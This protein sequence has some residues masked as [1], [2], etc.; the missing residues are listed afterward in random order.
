MSTKQKWQIVA[1]TIIT[2]VIVAGIVL[3]VIYTNRGAKGPQQATNVTVQ[4]PAGTQPNQPAGVPPTTPP[5]VSSN[6][7]GAPSV[8]TTPRQGAGTTVTP[9]PASQPKTPQPSKTTEA[10]QPTQGARQGAGPSESSQSL[11]PSTTM[12]TMYEFAATWCPACRQMKPVVD[13][14]KKQYDGRVDIIPVDVDQHPDM[15][16]K[17][18]ISSIPVQI[19][20]DVDGHEVYRHVGVTSKDSIIAQFR[21]MGVK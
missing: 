14:L 17:Y 5:A 8:T 3:A 18:N 4:G 12:P 2:A 20:L 11:Q 1:G 19:Y 21:K 16:K 13:E 9:Q 10:A 6:G 7:Q 15:T